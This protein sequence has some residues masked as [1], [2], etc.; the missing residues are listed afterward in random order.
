MRAGLLTGFIFFSG[1][2]F[3]QEFHFRQEPPITDTDV[4]QITILFQS[5]DH[6]VWLGTDKGIYAFD[7]HKYRHIPRPDHQVQ[8]VTAIAG[9][10]QGK[11]WVGYEDGYIHLSTLQGQN[12][13]IYA[14]SL[15][16]AV[17]SKILFNAAGD[18]FVTT[19]GKGVW[20]MK[21]DTLMRLRYKTLGQI[22][23]VYDALFDRD[24]RLWM[25]TD[26]GIWIYGAG[27]NETL[28]HIDALRGLPD[29][30]VTQLEMADNGDVLIGL[31]DH[32]LAVYEPVRDS[33][34]ALAPLLPSSGNVIGL[35]EGR[36]GEV[37]IGTEKSIVRYTSQGSCRL[38]IL[39]AEL[40]NRVESFLFDLNG[41][42]WVASGNKVFIANT[43]FEYSMPGLSGIQ[44][45]SAT[46]E[47]IW[48]GC[49]AG[50][51]AMSR[52]DLSVRAYLVNQNI[53]ILSL[54]TDPSGFLWIGTFGQGL[55]CFDP[56][57]GIFLRLTEE[58]KI[59]NNSILNID[60]RDQTIWLATLGG[61][62]ELQWSGNPMHNAINISGF[63][64][65]YG[66]PPGYVYDVYAGPD[67]KTWFGTDG[68]GLYVHQ[69]GEFRPVLISPDT[70][71]GKEKDIKTIYSITS[72]DDQT[73]WIS[74][75]MG[76]IVQLDST[77]KVIRQFQGSQGLINT[78]VS[79][80]SGEILMVREGGIQI[81]NL[82]GTMNYYNESSG[83]NLFTPNIN[84]AAKDKDGSIWIADA[85]RIVHYTPLME[86]TS[87]MVRMHLEAVSPYALYT[88][89]GARLKPDSN[90]LDMRFAGL[91]YQDPENVRY[92]Y[93]L[94]GHDQE[95]IYTRE[96]RAVYSRLS[97]GTYTFIV[98]GSHNEDFSKARG[99]RRE[100]VVIPPVYFRWWFVLGT[101]LIISLL[102]FSYIL[103]RIKRIKKMAQLEKEKTM[104]RLHAIQAQVN[105]HFLFNSFNTLSGIIEDDQA[106]AVDYV[107]QL[108]GFFRGALMH[109]NAEL[110]R[111]QE[112]IEIVRNY[113]YILQKR[114][115]TNLRID[116]DIQ[117]AN[118][119]IAPLSIQLLVENAIKHNIVSAEKPLT[120]SIIVDSH[121]VTVSNPVQPKINASTEST[122][123]GLSSLLARYQYLT[124]ERIEI[125]NEQNTFTVTIPIIDTDRPL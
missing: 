82:Q 50:L 38:L 51:F 87:Q 90:F 114:Y 107:D 45:V 110:I 94:K 104:L 17:I 43:R 121:R 73:L 81:H 29:E 27:G 1:F 88:D 113:T 72:G 62:T 36:P 49:E 115:G 33:V 66:F 48:L 28:S 85:D 78:L 80:G 59:S 12:Q 24:G 18:L 57:S 75:A 97:P 65:K 56:E 7:G 122:G 89:D 41:N 74:G 99:L 120:I 52:K 101:S 5:E 32:G 54:Y 39:P 70:T 31:Y 4:R 3:S 15:K 68:K 118:G 106:A 93:M 117:D 76:Q 124:R 10:P 60:G 61:I 125:R 11:I 112:E 77:G 25:A 111:I 86:D 95:W 30:I 67:G 103:A 119:W 40:N 8:N 13:A 42:L 96:G 35:E 47:R 69:N 37:W 109:R 116:E 23:D 19:Y 6:M 92:R 79:S 105:P 55:Y 20:T 64:D 26:N 16:G 63:Q 44:A 98:E 123:F 102:F 46:D 58:D 84:A 2:V 34:I 21:G 108:S 100:F 83:L 53:N 9:S 22:D 14:D 91:W 71:S